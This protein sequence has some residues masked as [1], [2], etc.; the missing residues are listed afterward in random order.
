MA[1]RIGSLQA[2][3]KDVERERDQLKDKLA[4]SAG[5]DLAQQA[6]ELAG[7]VK[8]LV[9]DLPGVEA[10]SLRNVVDQL[11]DKL[12]SAVVVLS[13]S[14]EGKISLVAGVTKALSATVKAGDVVAHIAQQVGGKGG[15]RHDMAMG[16]GS[17]V[18][19]LPQALASVQAWVEDKL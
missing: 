10:K 6:I 12:Q 17:D 15:G 1:S 7:G 18:A 8:L 13:T 11:K 16:G 9:A 3:L 4:S 14:E 19:A 2:Q 5:Q